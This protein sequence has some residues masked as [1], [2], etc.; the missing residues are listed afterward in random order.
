MKLNDINGYF[1]ISERIKTYLL[2]C[3]FKT[4]IL[5]YDEK[6]ILRYYRTIEKG[7]KF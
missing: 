4:N 2:I 3:S 1:I 5:Y 6:Y 7:A